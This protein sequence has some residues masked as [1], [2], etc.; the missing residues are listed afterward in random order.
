MG[1]CKRPIHA[2]CAGCAICWESTQVV[3]TIS[4]WISNTGGGSGLGH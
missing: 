3:R 2:A 4:K 1:M